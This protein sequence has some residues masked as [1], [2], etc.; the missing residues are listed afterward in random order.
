[1]DWAKL[2]S[3]SCVLQVGYS[4]PSQP[5]IM[6]DLDLS[7]A[8][9][10]S[11]NRVFILL[12]G[13]T[14]RWVLNWLWACPYAVLC[15]WLDTNHWSN[16]RSYCQWYRGRL[17]RPKMRKCWSQFVPVGW[18]CRIWHVPKLDRQQ[19]D[20]SYDLQFSLGSVWQSCAWLLLFCLL[21]HADNGNIRSS[22][23][24]WI[25]PD[26]IFPGWP[27]SYARVCSSIPSS[28]TYSVILWFRV[29]SRRTFGGLT[30]DGS[31]LDVESAFFH[32]WWLHKATTC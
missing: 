7:L 20:H 24:S 14:G 22:L 5:G 27:L 10:P 16:A 6:R 3:F 17:C 4:S 8:E 30:S 32:M 1:M 15:L 31:Q 13:T 29:I 9:V 18:A 28:T 2:V 26:N 12:T 25:S 23:H 21:R 11:C 19:R